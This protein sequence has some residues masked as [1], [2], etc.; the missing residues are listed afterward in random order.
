MPE[1]TSVARTVVPNRCVESGWPC[2]GKRTPSAETVIQVISLMALLSLV[3]F[4]AFRQRGGASRRFIATPPS[5]QLTMAGNF[6]GKVK[7]AAPEQFEVKRGK[8][9][10]AALPDWMSSV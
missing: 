8:W 2:F 9:T 7:Y 4:V 1:R 3:A 6:L 10:F 5:R